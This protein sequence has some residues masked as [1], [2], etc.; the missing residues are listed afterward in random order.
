MRGKDLL[1]VAE[2]RMGAVDA[3]AIGIYER[4]AG[5]AVDR[6]YEAL[7]RPAT[8]RLIG[9]AREANAKRLIWC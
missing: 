5:R 1:A 4:V 7:R 2:A 3:I 8:L 9:A 6:S